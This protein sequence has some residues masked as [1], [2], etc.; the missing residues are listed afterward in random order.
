ME[1]LFYY[2]IEQLLF[3]SRKALHYFNSSTSPFEIKINDFKNPISKPLVIPQT[4]QEAIKILKYI[5]II[6]YSSPLKEHF[7][8]SI[9]LL[10]T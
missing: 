6:D 7:I 10:A 5:S 2:C 1:K 4:L 8:Q 3:L 9:K